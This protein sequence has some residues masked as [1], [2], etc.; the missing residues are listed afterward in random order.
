[1][2]SQSY[3]FDPSRYEGHSLPIGAASHAADWGFTDAHIRLL[4]RWKSNA[5]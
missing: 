3:G 4:G 5:F 2:A 1:M